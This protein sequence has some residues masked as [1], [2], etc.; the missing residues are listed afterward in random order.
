[1]CTLFTEGVRCVLFV[2]SDWGVVLSGGRF[3]TFERC[4]V[5][6]LTF[7]RILFVLWGWGAVLSDQSG[8]LHFC[9]FGR[10]RFCTFLF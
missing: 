10:G 2:L 1:M 6:F 5:L 8:L 4:F 7:E 3:C 9:A